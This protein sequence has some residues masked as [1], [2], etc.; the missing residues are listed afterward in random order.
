MAAAAYKTIAECKSITLAS[1]LLQYA[2]KMLALS[3]EAIEFLA[4]G[5]VCGVV[6]FGIPDDYVSQRLRCASS[7]MSCAGRCSLVRA[8]EP[9]ASG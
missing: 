3:D 1:Q 5:E 7:R 9:C 6:R 2:R 8:S 4:K